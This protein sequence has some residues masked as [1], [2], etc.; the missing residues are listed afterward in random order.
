MPEVENDRPSQSHRTQ[1]C[2]DFLFEKLTDEELAEFGVCLTHSSAKTICTLK[3]WFRKVSVLFTQ[4]T[5]SAPLEKAVSA[6][7]IRRLS[8]PPVEKI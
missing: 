2:V 1:V 6:I 4:E 7:V 5:L 8:H 3:P